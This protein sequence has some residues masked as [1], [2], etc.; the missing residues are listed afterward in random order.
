MTDPAPAFLWEIVVDCAD[1]AALGR[2]YAALCAC[3]LHVHDDEWTWI[4]PALRGGGAPDSGGPRIAF[5]RVPEP[6]VGK[7]RLHL[8]L[9]ADDVAATVERAVSLGA[10]RVQDPVTDSAGTYVVLTDPEGHEF[11]VVDA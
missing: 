4:E 2:F 9:G 1:P 8:D 6:K 3:E 5:Q 7:V 10:A 11:C